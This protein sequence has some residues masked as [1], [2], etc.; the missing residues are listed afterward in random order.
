MV[1]P[2]LR[3]CVFELRIPLDREAL[4]RASLGLRALPG[5][6]LVTLRAPLPETEARALLERAGAKPSRAL[7]PTL[8]LVEGPVG[9]GSLELAN[10]LHAS[11]AFAG[12]QPNWWTPRT[13]K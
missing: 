8:W 4:L 11:G 6:V 5:G 9:L 2:Q 7:A 3:W 1:M 13:L 10:A 12:A